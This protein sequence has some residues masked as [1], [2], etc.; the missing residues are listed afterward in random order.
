MAQEIA[1]SWNPTAHIT[2]NVA[3]RMAEFIAGSPGAELPTLAVELPPLA[4][5]GNLAIYV[6][7]WALLMWPHHLPLGRP[8]IA[9]VFAALACALRSFCHAAW[10]EKHYATINIFS[11]VDP[12]PIALLFGLFL[13]NAYLKETGIWRKMQIMLDSPSPVIMLLKICGVSAVMSA[14]LLNDT[15]CLVL[16]PMVINLCRKHKARSALPF[17]LGISMSCNIGSALT[18]I[19]NPQNALIASISR[20]ITFVGFM[21]VML[22]PVLI[23]MCLNTAALVMWFRSD[24]VFEFAEAAPG[25]MEPEHG[26]P[27]LDGRDPESTHTTSAALVE[28]CCMDD[29][30]GGEQ[31]ERLRSVYLAAVA[32]AVAAMLAGWA[33]GLATDDVALATGCSL[34]AARSIRRRLSGRM[35]G[36]TE[37]DFAVSAVDPSILVLFFGQ[38]VLVGATVDTGVPQRVFSGVLG[39]CASHLGSSPPCIFWFSIMVMFL[40]NVISNVPVILM[41]QPLLSGQPAERL[42]WQICAW[43]ATVSGNLTMLGSAA[44]LIVAHGAESMGETSYTA[45]SVGKFSI[46]P[47]LMVSAVGVMLQP[48][49]RP[50]WAWMLSVVGAIAAAVLALASKAGFLNPAMSQREAQRPSSNAASVLLKAKDGAEDSMQ[51]A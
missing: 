19:G 30:G 39:G 14:F 3:Q 32:V 6:A 4:I 7:A 31:G 13:V 25:E 5:W 29:C 37:T 15:M 48:P 34:M 24:L 33:L 35:E 20:G 10:P 44:N 21:Q 50:H 8:G 47:T 1:I 51:G 46:L 40:S 43:V 22:T 41:L 36:S 9:M 17:L 16:T 2:M 42:V 11:K 23:G 27:S 45:T 28:D 49:L 26:V 18:I 38:F 12:T